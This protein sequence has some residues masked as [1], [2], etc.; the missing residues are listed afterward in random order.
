MYP[1][2]WVARD[3]DCHENTV[4]RWRGKHGITTKGLSEE[5]L[6]EFRQ[7]REP[8]LQ[9]KHLRQKARTLGMSENSI[10]DMLKPKHRRNKSQEVLEAT[11]ERNAPRQ[12]RRRAEPVGASMAAIS[13]EDQITELEARLAE[14]DLN[15]DEWADAYDN[16]ERLRQMQ[17]GS[18]R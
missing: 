15:S 17:Q 2:S 11:I 10:K 4:A 5:Q 7:A 8:K 12:Q 13:I 16:R 3:V 9:R 18:D 6:E 1:D 14:A